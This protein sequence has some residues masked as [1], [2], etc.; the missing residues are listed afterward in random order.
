MDQV[1]PVLGGRFLY[2]GVKQM[3]FS[4]A[5]YLLIG[6]MSGALTGCTS[7]KAT[8]HSGG[9]G[10]SAQDTPRESMQEGWKDVKKGSGEIAEGIGGATKEAAHDVSREV[11]ETGR[12]LKASACPVIG[13]RV[14]KKYY[15]Q[16][17]K[18]YA[19][20]LKGEKIL[21][22]DQRECFMSETAALED[23]YKKA[24]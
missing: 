8:N 14:T 7:S 10:T 21:S 24:R 5:Q 16:S 19:T 9:E 3:T 15:T 23:G 22:A 11:R 18:D 17:D 2:Q 13:H 12:Q 1:L 4:L 20:M 6:M